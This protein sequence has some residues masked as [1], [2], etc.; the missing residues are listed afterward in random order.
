MD[1]ENA[2]ESLSQ[3]INH[4]NALGASGGPAAVAE[5]EEI[6]QQ[7]QATGLGVLHRCTLIFML[8][9]AMTNLAT[10][11]GL[12]E[13]IQL[14]VDWA[15]RL[16]DPTTT[17]PIFIPQ[18]AYNRAN[19]LQQIF[20]I[21]EAASNGEPPVRLSNPTFRLENLG[22]LQPVRVLFD[23]V[24]RDPSMPAELHGRSLCNLG[25]VLDESGRWVEAYSAYSDALKADPTNGNAAG[26]LAEL[27][28]R[29]LIFGSD[30]LGHIAAVYD[31]YVLIAQSLR[32]RTIEIAGVE[33]ADRWDALKL[34][35]SPG[36]LSHDGDE[37]DPYQKWIVDCRLA[38]TATVEGLGSDSPR[39]DSASVTG[40]F[41][42][43][44]NEA[45]PGIFAAMNVLKAEYVVARRL[46]FRGHHMLEESQ[47]EQHPED[48]GLYTDTLDSAF[49]GEPAALLLLAQRSALDVLDKIAV[50]ANEHF[51]SGLKPSAV[52][53]VKYW[54]DPKTREI[55]PA[56]T[57]PNH[58]LRSRLALAEL[59]VDLNPDGLYPNARLLRNAGT[60]RLVHATYGLPTG[61][62]EDTFSTV[63]ID[64]LVPSTLEV[65]RVARA[66]YL[67][68][69]DLVES[70]L[71][72][73]DPT[74]VIGKLPNQH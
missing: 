2:F 57:K 37:L 31:K 3:R 49:Y 59:V 64:D 29:R 51:G 21:K 36:H 38:L 1:L 18:A 12:I 58:G 34:T 68:F 40:F 44:D 30:Q 46:A 15:T 45:V 27:L 5:L 32:E 8:S 19:G 10:D 56:L 26:N 42:A 4:I 39:W 70:Q 16:F 28:R 74:S 25:N 69:V 50:T 72:E 17:P 65:L 71:S 55:R 47:Y 33:V 52:T 35:S 22:E 41:P 20:E 73:P 62:T 53:F 67:Y 24:G 9:S 63:N 11:L 23:M 13:K 61:P 66:A 43:D 48:P 60:H 7:V 14:G 6:E 54:K